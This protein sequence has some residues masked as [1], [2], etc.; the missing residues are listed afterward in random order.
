M[1]ISTNLMYSSSLS[2]FNTQNAKIADLRE[3]ISSGKKHI[4]ASDDPSGS[5][6]ATELR[7][8]GNAIKQYQR[9][10]DFANNRISLQESTLRS[11]VDGVQRLREL[12]VQAG[13]GTYDADSLKNMAEEVSQTNQML[14]GLANT[15]DANG[16]YLFAGVAGARKPVDTVV[17]TQLVAFDYDGAESVRQIKISE[18]RSIDM[19]VSGST[20]F[21]A[22][23]SSSALK[24]DVPFSNTGSMVAT[25]AFVSDPDQRVAGAEYEVT[26]G[27][28]GTTIDV[29]NTSS[30]GSVL[31]GVPYTPGQVLEFEGIAVQMD[32]A[33]NA[34]DKV[35][36]TPGSQ[37]DVFTSANKFSHALNTAGNDP[38]RMSAL[39]TQAIEDLDAAL[40]SLLE[41]TAMTGV[42]MR[43]LEAEK[44]GHL[45][46]SLEVSKNLSNVE[47]VDLA[48]AV[49]SLAKESN[50]LEAAQASFGRINQMSLFKYI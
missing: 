3:Q 21:M 25:P 20:A 38:E 15:K 42:Q 32:G 16:E 10:I 41:A 6:R 43:V 48:E 26:F 47:D 4:R 29:V 36:I 45:D 12:A 33:A 35:V 44:N 5:V 1:R 9:N 28:G 18:T 7:Q 19:G 49:S 24:T 2:A 37:Q 46:S 22:T 13:N 31:S 14:A 40:N 11:A 8:K 23:N 27:A 50:L 34:G 39:S 30:G 17:Q